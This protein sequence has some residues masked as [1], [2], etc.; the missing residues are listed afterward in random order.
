MRFVEKEGEDAGME[1]VSDQDFST[2]KHGDRALEHVLVVKL[3]FINHL[4]IENVNEENLMFS[5][6]EIIIQS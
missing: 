4:G 5:K 3:P 2:S 1:A 6:L